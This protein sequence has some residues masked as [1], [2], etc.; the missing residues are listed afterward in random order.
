MPES[1]AAYTVTQKTLATCQK[2]AGG[3]TRAVEVGGPPGPYQTWP[4]SASAPA[5]APRPPPPSA[6]AGAP[7][8][9]RPRRRRAGTCTPV[10]GRG[11]GGAWTWRGGVWGWLGHPLAPNNYAPGFWF[12][13][14][15]EGSHGAGGGRF[16]GQA[17]LRMLPEATL[18]PRRTQ[19]KPERRLLGAR[20]RGP[21]ISPKSQS[22]P[23]MMGG[24]QPPPKQ[25]NPPP[26]GLFGK[27]R[28]H[29]LKVYHN[30]VMVQKNYF[31]GG[32]VT[33]KL[34]FGDI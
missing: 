27:A 5:A 22:V 2:N 8:S 16:M 21:G 11:W 7:P 9:P 14:S 28:F 26:P 29:S 12:A 30:F 34:F 33:H 17:S 6:A 18:A 19:L 32:Q 4:A 15:P 25:H 24:R 3:A 10:G 1:R 13:G 23:Q 20:A 31:G